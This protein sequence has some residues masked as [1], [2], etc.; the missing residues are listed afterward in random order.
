MDHGEPHMAVVV[1]VA[2]EEAPVD[3]DLQCHT[4]LIGQAGRAD[5]P[6]GVSASLVDGDHSGE[7][8]QH[9]PLS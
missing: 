7:S 4:L 2:E 6:S 3:E 5:L 9:I 1:R 8:R